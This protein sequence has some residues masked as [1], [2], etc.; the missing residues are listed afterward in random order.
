MAHPNNFLTARK[1]PNQGKHQGSLI[2]I[3]ADEPCGR[4]QDCDSRI[5][6]KDIN[7][8]FSQHYFTTLCRGQSVNTIKTIRFPVLSGIDDRFINDNDILYRFGAI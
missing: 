4:D 8:P 2:Y 1:S 5:T 3:Q 7:I 6:L